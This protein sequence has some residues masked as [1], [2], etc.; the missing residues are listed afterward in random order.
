MTDRIVGTTAR[1]NIVAQ[2]KKQKLAQ[3]VSAKIMKME[4]FVTLRIIE[5]AIIQKQKDV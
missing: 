1:I 5:L 2:K 3:A 4:K